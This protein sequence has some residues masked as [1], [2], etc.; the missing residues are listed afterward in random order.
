MSHLTEERGWLV[1]VREVRR[2]ARWGGRG[3]RA[4]GERKARAA[5]QACDEGGRA[6]AW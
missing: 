5:E 2:V 1:Y 6:G 4:A 3:G